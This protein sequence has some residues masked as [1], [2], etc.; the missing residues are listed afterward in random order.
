MIH[1]PNDVICWCEICENYR[2]EYYA[3]SFDNKQKAK[4][5]NELVYFLLGVGSILGVIVLTDI[6]GFIIWKV[7]GQVPTDGFFIGALTN[8]II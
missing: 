2:H 8:F 3:T 7:S 1:N 5:M 4:A 6:V